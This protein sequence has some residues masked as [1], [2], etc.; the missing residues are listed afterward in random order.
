MPRN[1]EIRKT[2]EK[3]SKM[4]EKINKIMGRSQMAPQLHAHSADDQITMRIHA[5]KR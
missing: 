2:A 5:T 4:V 3:I 1:L